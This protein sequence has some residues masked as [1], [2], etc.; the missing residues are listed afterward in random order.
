MF[1]ESQY[2]LGSPNKEKK[3]LKVKRP[4][5]RISDCYTPL[6]GIPNQGRRTNRITIIY[7]SNASNSQYPA[8]HTIIVNPL[9]I[10]IHAFPLQV[11]RLPHTF[12]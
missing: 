12:T 10:S 7:F 5:N 4:I 3:P 2:V 11:F 9:R 6:H 8:L 1:K